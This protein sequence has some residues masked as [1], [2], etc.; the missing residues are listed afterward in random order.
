MTQSGYLFIGLHMLLFVFTAYMLRNTLGDAFDTTYYLSNEE[1]MP[2]YCTRCCFI[3]SGSS[4][5]SYPEVHDVEEN[6]QTE[7]SYID[8]EFA[9]MKDFNNGRPSNKSIASAD[10]DRSTLPPTPLDHNGPRGSQNSE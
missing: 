1:P 7:D 5:T 6:P 2:S 4:T 8:I 3:Y 10:G 9:D